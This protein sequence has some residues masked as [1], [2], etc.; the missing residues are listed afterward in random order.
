MKKNNLDF[1]ILVSFNEL[2]WV[3]VFALLFSLTFREKKHDTEVKDYNEQI[4]QLKSN[5]IKKDNDINDLKIK[6]GKLSE[7]PRLKQELVGIK[8]KLGNVVFIVD[9][10][11]SMNDRG[12]QRWKKVSRIIKIWLEHLPIEQAALII[13]SDTADIYPED[14]SYLN[15]SGEEHN[16]NRKL[17][18][19][20]FNVIKPKGNTNTI[21]ALR[22]AY[23]TYSQIDTIVIFTDG[24][25]DK[26]G[27]NKFDHNMANAIYKLCHEH[28]AIPI[29]VIGLGQ[30]FEPE[31]GQF[32]KQL[33]EISG[34]NFIGY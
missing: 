31:L 10:S 2:A 34:G 26:N 29:N 4:S 25:P 32:L 20:Q 14:G 22:K 9:R 27:S 5:V 6:L 13:F 18:L 15:V 8:G 12:G 16:A 19:E 11:G 7:T 24:A 1:S 33:P 28:N 30:Y 23:T 17:L 21:E 3:A